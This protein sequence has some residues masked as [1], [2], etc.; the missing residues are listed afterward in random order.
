MQNSSFQEEKDL[1][2]ISG[3][4]AVGCPL[5]LRIF[6]VSLPSSSKKEYCPST[7]FWPK[8]SPKRNLRILLY[9]KLPAHVTISHPI[10]KVLILHFQRDTFLRIYLIFLSHKMIISGVLASGTSQVTVLRQPPIM[11][12]NDL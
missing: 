4:H 1:Q 3:C 11:T 2:F 10:I 5:V 8:T 6:R 12:L 7:G 9:L